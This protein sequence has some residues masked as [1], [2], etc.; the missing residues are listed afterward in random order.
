LCP[1]GKPQKHTINIPEYN[2]GIF[3]AVLNGVFAASIMVPLHYA[4]PN[5]TQGIGYSMSFGI[6]AGVVVLAIWIIRW[7]FYSSM[8]LVT[9]RLW[10]DHMGNRRC[11]KIIVALKKG[12]HSLPSFHVKEMWRPGLLS[13]LLYS[14]GNL[15]GIVSIQRLGNF[16]GYSLNQS[17]IIVS[18]K[19][20]IPIC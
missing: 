2:I 15:M 3:M 13:G 9:E 18:G 14:V 10:G 11:T 6:A 20:C 5:A 7:L 16:M 12:Y 19:S 8:L 17:S 1:D 4:P